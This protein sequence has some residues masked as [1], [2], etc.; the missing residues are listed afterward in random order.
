MKFLLRCL[1]LFTLL[2]PAWASADY[3]LGTGDFVKVTVYGDAELM[4][5]VR[6]AENGVLSFPLIGEV[7]VGGL[8]TVEAEKVISEQLKKGGF[9]ANPQVSV[10]VVQF[11]SKTVSVLGGV[12]KPGRYPVTRPSDIKDMIAEAGGITSEG[13]EI[14]TLVSGDKRS[15]FDLH[16]VISHKGSK[17]EITVIGGETIY[18]G[19]RDVAV[20]GQLLRPAK[21]SIQGGMRKIS[22][23][24]SLAGGPTEL[25]GEVLFYTTS[26]SS[27]PVTEEINIDAL[28]KSPNTAQNKLVHPGDVLYVPR[29]PQVYVYGEVQRPGMYKIDKNM[30]V[31]QAIAKAGGL[32]IRGTQRSTKLHRKNEQGDVSKQNPELSTS[33]KDDDVLYIEESMF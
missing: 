13:S 27:S 8:T 18:V 19:T 26:V 16:E 5:E 7:R 31:M 10:V 4:R 14:V 29:A 11:L 22:D 20:V 33:L 28:F 24:I 23:F 15:E 1:F 17:D 25:A 9:I 2:M 3:T 6:V 21:Y 12:L 32:T 30:T